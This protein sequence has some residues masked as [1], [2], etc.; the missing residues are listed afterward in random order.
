MS[1]YAAVGGTWKS[2]LCFL[3]VAHL[4]S[5]RQAR[6]ASWP[7]EELRTRNREKSQIQRTS[8]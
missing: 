7:S 3:E 2:S 4:E 1:H 8:A 5:E 6:L